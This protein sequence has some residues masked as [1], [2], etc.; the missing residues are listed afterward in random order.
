[1]Y[2]SYLLS[3]LVKAKVYSKFQQTIAK[4]LSKIFFF[5]FFLSFLLF[6]KSTFKGPE[7]KIGQFFMDN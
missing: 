6:P 7:R 1:M 5:F 4:I 3:S 2:G